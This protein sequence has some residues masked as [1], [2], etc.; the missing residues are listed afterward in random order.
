VSR[1]SKAPFDVNGRTVFITGAARGIGAAAAER[2]H[3]K[4]AN[5]ALVGLEPERMEQN[6]AALGERAAFF[7]DDVTDLSALQRAVEATVDRF[8][9]IDVAIANAG[10]AESDRRDR[11]GHRA[12][13]RTPLVPALGRSRDRGARD[14]AAID[15]TACAERSDATVGGH[16][17]R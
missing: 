4:G 1:S 10:I 8:G 5:V 12:A 17:P 2:L 11:A 14:P 6:A 16:P 9:G 15:R 7:E 13:G 3:A